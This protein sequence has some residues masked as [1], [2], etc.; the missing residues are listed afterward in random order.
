[1]KMAAANAVM[2]VKKVIYPLRFRNLNSPCMTISTHVWYLW[3]S[4]IYEPSEDEYGLFMANS[5]TYVFVS[6]R[7]PYLGPSK[8]HKHGVSIPYG[9][10]MFT[11]HDS[12]INLS[13]Q[14]LRIFP[15]GISQRP[16][17]LRDCLNIHLLLPL[18]FLTLFVE[19]FWWWCESENRQ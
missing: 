15:A 1:M 7:S 9:D 16:E 18:W 12:L 13:K 10:A 8:R 6:C 17:S 5:M 4:D 14:F 2:W 19:R 11:P 3:Y